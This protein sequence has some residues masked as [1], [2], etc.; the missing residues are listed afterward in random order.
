[1]PPKQK[2]KGKK[3][4]KK[5]KDDAELTIEDKYKKTIHEIEALK[6]HLANRKELARRSQVHSEEWKGRM[7]SA[8][9][10]L[11]Q[12]KV[13]QRDVTSDMTRQYKTM[14]TEMSMRIH[15]LEAELGKVKVQLERTQVELKE[16]KAEKEKITEE[17]NQKISELETKI[18]GMELAYEGVLHDA[19]D[20]MVAK[21][22]LAKNR[23]KNE[24]TVIH[25]ENKQRLL[26]FGLNPIDL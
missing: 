18:D 5:K 21:L 20:N 13:D 24:A 17:K 11:V 8:E 19:L 4:G 16:T 10:A 3:K 1:M 6:D 26:E 25:A 2:G 7:H 14:Q 23:W 22:D 15:Q 9:E 12:Q